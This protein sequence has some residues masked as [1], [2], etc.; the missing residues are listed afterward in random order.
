MM[1]ALAVIISSISALFSSVFAYQACSLSPQPSPP[2]SPNGRSSV[3]LSPAEYPSAEIVSPVNTFPIAVPPGWL[4]EPLGI[5]K[6]RPSWHSGTPQWKDR[7]RM[8]FV[9]PA[10]DWQ[11][12]EDVTE[13]V[14]TRWTG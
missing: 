14:A 11:S 13:A 2:S 12:V 1:N 3:W 9:H 4:V 10:N 7:V 8:T 6:S 5:R